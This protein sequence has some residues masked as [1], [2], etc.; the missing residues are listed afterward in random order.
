MVSYWFACGKV[1]GPVL[2]VWW[3]FTGLFVHFSFILCGSILPVAAMPMYS[4]QAF[5]LMAKEHFDF[6]ED[7][8]FR[9][10]F[11]VSQDVCC[12]AWEW[13]RNH[14]RAPRHGMKGIHLL[15]ALHFLKSYNTEDENA[16]WAHTTRKT[17][18]KWVWI[19]LRLLRKMKRELV[20]CHQ[21]RVVV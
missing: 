5:W 8:G 16:S 19:M 10:L 3:L 14:K 1:T 13:C 2:W 21:C 9:A 18:R 15:W 17:F 6:S 12:L 7:R 4:P 20:C 11:G